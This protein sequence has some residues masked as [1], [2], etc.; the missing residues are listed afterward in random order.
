MCSKVLQ[1]TRYTTGYIESESGTSQMRKRD[2]VMKP[3][4]TMVHE[5]NEPGEKVIQNKNTGGKRGCRTGVC[6]EFVMTIATPS[7]TDRDHSVSFRSPE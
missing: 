4:G 6:C 1:N 3:G 2:V 7:T 5:T